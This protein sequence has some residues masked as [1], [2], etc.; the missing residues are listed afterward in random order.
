M[1]TFLAL[2]VVLCLSG[3]AVVAVTSAVVLGRR[4]CRLR[5]R[6]GRNH[7]RRRH[8]RCSRRYR[9]GH[10]GVRSRRAI[11]S[12]QANRSSECLSAISNWFRDAESCRTGIVQG[13]AVRA[14]HVG[15][16]IFAGLKNIVGGELRAIPN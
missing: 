3:C 15:K 8:H 2:S 5:G 4:G 10:R 16:D 7:S 12:P 13:S 1:R 6:V 11:P 9:Q 14:K